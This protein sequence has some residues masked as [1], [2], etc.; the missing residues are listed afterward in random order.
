MVAQSAAERRAESLVMKL[1]AIPGVSRREGKVAQWIVRKLRAAGVPDDRIRFDGAEQRTPEPGEV[2][3]LIVSLPGTRRG[4][5]RLLSAHLDTVPICEG[6]RP[7]KK[8]GLVVSADPNTGLG[9]DNRAGCAVILHALLE[10]LRRNEPHPPLTFA[11]FVQEEIGL[12]GARCVKKSL[13]GRPRWGF[14]WDGGSP[15]KLTIGA[16]GGY[17]MRIRIQGIPAHAG[18]APE[19]GASAITM[20]SLAIA[21]LHRHGWLGQV[22][23]REGRGTSNVGVIHGGSATNVVADEV[24]LLAE[25]RSH[26]RGFRATIL[27][28]YV[29]AFEQAVAKVRNVQG[30]GGTVDIEGRLDY[31]SY[32]LAPDEPCVQIAAREARAVGL[33]PELAVANGGLDANW[34][35]AHGIPTVSIGC[36]QINQHM[37]SEALDL[38]GF[39]QACRLAHQLVRAVP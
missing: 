3:N 9:A 8:D 35:N 29:D 23:K 26:D 11:W 7:A 25:A 38:E 28:A 5:R 16:T 15:A 21:D 4:P 6:S 34:L 14:N 13:L 24:E 18:G 36:G 27:R 37:V 31:E 32:R 22:A 30:D 2:G 20:A 39:Q 1:M 12:Q 17:R 19:R 33:T 10:L